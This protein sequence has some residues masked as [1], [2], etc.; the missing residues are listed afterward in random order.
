MHW[1][2]DYSRPVRWTKDGRLIYVSQ[3]KLD[4][5]VRS[6]RETLKR[7][8]NH[9]TI[10]GFTNHELYRVCVAIHLREDEIEIY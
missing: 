8:I 9:R 10:D 1:R 6:L 3:P 7:L 2:R 5:I 4:P